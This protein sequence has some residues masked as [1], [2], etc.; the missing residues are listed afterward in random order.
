ME[1]NI[2]VVMGRLEPYLDRLD[3]IVRH[4][5]EVYS[6]YPPEIAIDYSGG[7][8][9]N[10]TYSHIKAEAHGVLDELPGVRHIEIRGQHLWLIEPANAVCRFKKT[11]EDG[12]SANYPT[13]QA[14]AFDRGEP[15]PGLPQEPTRLTIGY[16]LDASGIGFVR[17]QASLPA[18]RQTLWCAAIVPVDAREVGEAA[19]Y[20]VT[21]QAR[22]G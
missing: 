19:W 22:L 9:A 12:A 1:T 4:G 6:S 16:L 5:H 3:K 2:A 17:S 21:K 18:G 14:K 10:C 20:E 8:Q 11:D 15:L 7:T 13:R